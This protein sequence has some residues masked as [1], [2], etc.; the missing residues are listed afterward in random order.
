MSR[1]SKDM[2]RTA[3]DR[4]ADYDGLL[5]DVVRVIDDARHAAA[6][7]VNAV[8]TATYWLVGRRIV[9]REQQGQARAAYGEAVLERLAVD[10]TRRFGRGFS[11]RNLRQMRAFYIGWPNRQA[12]SA[13]SAAGEPR[14]AAPAIRQTPSA[15]SGPSSPA[16]PFPLPW[17]HY[18]RLLQLENH[19]A[20]TFYETE[21]LRGGW[22]FRQLDP[23]PDEQTIAAELERTRKILEQRRRLPLN[24]ETRPPRKRARRTRR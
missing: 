24:D 23:L 21:A 5:A 20:R 3:A 10:L 6:R 16:V 7:S 13:D 12:V 14:R 1:A 19:H 8:M 17:S 2:T 15:E 11:V 18:A 22:S 4:A 9:E